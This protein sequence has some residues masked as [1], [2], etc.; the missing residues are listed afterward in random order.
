[1][2][3]KKDKEKKY[4]INFEIKSPFVKLVG[5]NV[6]NGVYPLKEAIKIA[7]E[8]N[9]DLVEVAISEN[10]SICKIMDYNKYLYEKKKQAKE[11][12]GKQSIVK[13]VRISPFIGQ[14]DMEIKARHIRRFLE[15]KNKVMLVLIIKK[16]LYEIQ[17]ISME[18]MHQMI[19]LVEDVAK[20]EIE[21]KIEGRKIIAMLT[22]KKK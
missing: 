17:A 18:K 19:K 2:G 13:E 9:L 14:H 5:N 21:P 12:K 11:S 16:N 1:M 7:Q 20:V 8:M 15:E 10:Q 4:R 3:D 22:P 6:P